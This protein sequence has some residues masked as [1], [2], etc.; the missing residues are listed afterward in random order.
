MVND[1]NIRL[2]SLVTVV[3]REVLVMGCLNRVRDLRHRGHSRGS[4]PVP[5]RLPLREGGLPMTVQTRNTVRDVHKIVDYT[6]SCRGEGCNS[7]Y[8]V[9]RQS[10]VTGLSN[11]FLWSPV[12]VIVTIEIVPS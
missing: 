11:R 4:S 5:S 8:V 3:T 7:N 9:R 12:R 2:R 10:K 1:R 6:V